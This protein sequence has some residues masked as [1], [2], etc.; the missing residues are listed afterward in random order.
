M[1]GSPLPTPGSVTVNVVNGSGVYDQGTNTANAL[2]ALGFQATANGTATPVGTY[3]ETVV[4]YTQQ[5][6]AVE[7]A[8]QAVA[9]SMSGAVIMAYEPPQATPSGSTAAEV[10]VTTGSSFAVTPPVPT[11]TTPS[12][13]TRPGPT[14]TTT[15]STTTTTTLPQSGAFAPTTPPVEALQAWDPRSCTPSGGVGP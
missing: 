3:A 5:T 2:G 15:P 13:T 1:T 4:S 9:D 12:S 7:A 10:T 8:A 14:P 11:A 6:P